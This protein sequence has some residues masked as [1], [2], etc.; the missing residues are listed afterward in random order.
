VAARRELSQAY[1]SLGKTNE[2]L[3]TVSRALKS[4]ADAADQAS[5]LMVRAGILRARREFEKALNDA[6]EAIRKYPNN[7]EWYLIRSQLQAS[8]N[9]K[10]E[11]VQGLQ[12]GIRTTGSGLL[13]AEWVDALIDAGQGTVALE[14]IEL[15][16][17]TSRWRSAWLIRRAR[18]RLALD[19]KQEARADL[20]AAL[21]ELNQRLS[22]G[23]SDA[24]L[25]ADRALAFELLDKREEARR[26]YR[27]ARDKGLTDEW[28]RERI[29]ALREPGKEDE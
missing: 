8:L 13:L 4:P 16:L 14:R 25:L 15:E 18:V 1:F 5:L 20:L 17:R 26:D 7:V 2:A 22:A 11:R 19:H 29:R 24:L 6:T 12:D 3:A 21:E 27:A 9:L 10:Q 28:V 23:A